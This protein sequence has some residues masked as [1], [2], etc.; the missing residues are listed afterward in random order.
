[1]LDTT[2]PSC[3]RWG[4]RTGTRSGGRVS[5]GPETVQRASEGAREAAS[6]KSEEGTRG[7]RCRR[8]EGRGSWR[9]AYRL[10][11][12]LYQRRH[13]GL[14]GEPRGRAQDEQLRLPPRG[15]HAVA[16]DD[17]GYGFGRQGVLHAVEDCAAA[18]VCAQVLPSPPG[19][20]E[21]HGELISGGLVQDLP[22]WEVGCGGRAAAGEISGVSDVERRHV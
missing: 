21:E 5:A 8:G 18:R 6:E 22:K 14:F 11:I 10:W 17:R 4:E 7:K 1:M 19:E 9:C 2:A 20:P 13:E 12:P 16:Q 3:D 15:L